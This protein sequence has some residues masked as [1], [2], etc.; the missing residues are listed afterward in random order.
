M[1]P[2]FVLRAN[3]DRIQSSDAGDFSPS[4]VATFF[5]S[6][7]DPVT[8][9]SGHRTFQA[10]LGNTDLKAEKSREQRSV[11]CSGTDGTSTGVNFGTRSTAKGPFRVFR[12][13]GQH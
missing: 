5:T 12:T 8:G 11:P 6:V 13:C 10:I 3:W 1:S 9:A 7:I 2:E 4:N